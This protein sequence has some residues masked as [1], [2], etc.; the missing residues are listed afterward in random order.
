MD[1][2]FP[3]INPVLQ[4]G[5]EPFLS[6]NKELS[7]DVLSFWQWSSSQLL[8]NRMR[9]ILAEFIVSKAVNS[10][11]HVR[12]EW[13]DYDLLTQEGV[14][15]EVKSAAYIQSWEQKTLSTIQFSI[16]PS[17]GYESEANKWTTY[18]KRWADVY[19]F[20]VLSHQEQESINPLNLD[21][22][23][24]YVLPTQVLDQKLP[25]QK[26]LRLSSLLKLIPSKVS[27]EE[28]EEAVR[29]SS[30]IRKKGSETLKQFTM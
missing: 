1:F 27:Y 14:K 3:A 20:C 16:A 23:D 29:V 8:D 9:G 24:F 13:D 10:V 18:K 6:R 30:I 4:S 19:V 25:E 28:L 22:W 2:P 11:T 26:T 12:E 15:V 7:F 5:D 17:E 21:Q